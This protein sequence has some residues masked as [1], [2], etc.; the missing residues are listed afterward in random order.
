MNHEPVYTLP[1]LPYA[2]N[3]LEPV[4]S[5]RIMELHHGTHHAAYVDNANRFMGE[6]AA[7]DPAADPTPL[8]RS[9][10][11]NVSGHRLHSLFW[12]C[13]TPNG[14]GL[15]APEVAEQIERFFGPVET[16]KAQMTLA[17]E[18]LAGSGWA[19]L[20]WEPTALRLVVTQI[21]DH[22]HDQITGAV[23]ILVIDGW[24]HA[25]YLQYEAGRAKWAAAFWDVVDWNGVGA[26][27]SELVS[28]SYAE[29]AV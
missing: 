19:A 14:G 20:V 22:Q 7:L 23:P 28:R 29:Q 1:V 6:L 11:F 15:P 4:V 27:L 12:Q 16:L 2:V 13:M 5:G 26:R 8:V 10:S 3:A 21:H 17:V 24:E 25:Y 18:K 9:L